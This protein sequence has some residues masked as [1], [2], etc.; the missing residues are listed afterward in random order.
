MNEL[1]KTQNVFNTNDY[2]YSLNNLQKR[3]QLNSTGMKVNILGNF[4]IGTG[5]IVPAFQQTG[6]WYEYF[7][8]DS[9]T[10]EGVNVPINLEPGE[11]RLYTTAK[12]KSPKLL[13]GIE[14]E[15][16]PDSEHFVNVYPNPSHGEFTIELRSIQLS[17][18]TIS[19][20]DLT[21]RLIRQMKSDIVTGG[22]QLFKWDGKTSY[23][24]EAGKGIYFIQTRTRG[25]SETVK[26]IKQ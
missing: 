22:S 2:S 20:L 17:P 24:A 25:R 18:V 19:I 15:Y 10:V 12:L 3:I 9:I 7:S 5:T 4:D 16:M 13:L 11:Y 23:G 21:G 8:D 1:R 14:D 26:I 6:K